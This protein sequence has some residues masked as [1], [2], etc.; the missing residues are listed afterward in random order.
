MLVDCGGS[1]AQGGS[2]LDVTGDRRLLRAVEK[3]VICW[4]LYRG[5]RYWPDK[6]S[7]EPYTALTA[8]AAPRGSY[9]LSLPAAAAIKFFIPCTLQGLLLP[10]NITG[11]VTTFNSQQILPK[12][13]GL[14]LYRT[15][16]LHTEWIGS[17]S[18]HHQFFC[19]SQCFFLSLGI[20]I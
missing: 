7:C 9:G 1:M 14:I 13:N 4:S 12:D 8:E 16:L 5:P 3:A 10:P 20:S 19:L 17:F 18:S 6:G 15:L 11:F 2:R